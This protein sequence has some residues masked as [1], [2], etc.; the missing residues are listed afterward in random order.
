VVMAMWFRQW[1]M[2]EA[3]SEV[4]VLRGV[5]IDNL[6]LGKKGSIG[7]QGRL[8]YVNGCL[9]LEANKLELI[10]HSASLIIEHP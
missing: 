8:I 6:I 7:H 2:E 3:T 10:N 1:V 4:E 5:T 9:N